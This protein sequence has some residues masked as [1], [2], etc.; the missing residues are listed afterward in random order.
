MSSLKFLVMDDM[1]S[2]LKLDGE[3]GTSAVDET[4][5]WPSTAHSG[6]LTNH[7]V[8]NWANMHSS[9]PP[10]TVDHWV[11]VRNTAMFSSNKEIV[12]AEY[13]TRFF[14][15]HSRPWPNFPSGWTWMTWWGRWDWINSGLWKEH[16]GTETF[17]S[18][19]V[20]FSSEKLR[21]H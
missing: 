17:C 1:G 13:R 15:I 4:N 9:P 20:P 12:C 3:I 10:R 16:S 21:S 18:W 8:G 11:V 19:C 6:P 2:D 7:M 5:H 14:R